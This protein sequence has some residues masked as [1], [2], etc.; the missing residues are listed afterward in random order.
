MPR[1][2][3][4]FARVVLLVALA[5]TGGQGQSA[6]TDAAKAGPGAKEPSVITSVRVVHERG[7]PAIEILS[8]RPVVPAIQ[9]LQS[10]PRLVID[11]P[12]SRAQLKFKRIPVLKE[13]IL[14]VRAEQYQT[15]PPVV[16]V[17]LDLESPYS[18]AWDAAGDR[19]MVRLKPAEDANASQQPPDLPKVLG[20][21]TVASPAAVPITGGTGAVVLAGSRIAAGSSVTA[22]SDTA[23]LR[24]ARGGEVRVCPGT[25]LSVTPSKNAHDLMLGISTGALEAHYA[26]A[27]SADSV[28]TPD[29]R[30][31]FAG[32]GEFHFAISA[33]S[34]GNTCVRA[35]MGNTSSAIVSE[36]M[37]DRIYQVKPAEQAVFHLGQIDKVGSDVP[38]ECGCPPPPNVLRAGSPAS[39]TL[40]EAQLPANANLAQGGKSEVDVPL[41]A[42]K[43]PQML[44]SGPETAPMPPSQ[45]TDVHIQVDAPFVF[46]AK[47]S[48]AATT[49]TAPPEIFN[50]PVVE[51]SGSPVHLYTSVQPPPAV[52]KPAPAAAAKHRTLLRRLKGF[53]AAVF[54]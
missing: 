5:T 13:H 28:L 18:C 4:H 29:F 7:A 33:D 19:L 1:P 44:S 26:L 46:T 30:I 6:A 11:L 42:N 24:L 51:R 17:V 38:L 8:T 41:S 32:P 40:P 35:L 12:N 23:I 31:L 14:A 22:G 2:A 16:R 20:L 49:S 27:A 15:S 3:D 52:E 10:P 53:F 48:S 37:G 25:T 36:L 47:T 34:H 9:T 21:G 45:P 43:P 39:P 54:G 50:L